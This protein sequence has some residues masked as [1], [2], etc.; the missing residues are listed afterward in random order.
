MAQLAP[1]DHVQVRHRRGRKL[2]GVLYPALVLAVRHG[3]ALLEYQGKSYTGLV[4]CDDRAEDD[5][6]VSETHRNAY[7]YTALPHKWL[8]AI[9]DAEQD[10]QG[11]SRAGET[12]S[13]YELLMERKRDSVAS[14]SPTTGWDRTEDTWTKSYLGH[15]LR[16]H[17]RLGFVFAQVGSLEV[18]RY[19]KR[20]K[21]NSA[22][23]CAVFRTHHV[24]ES[25]GPAKAPDWRHA[26]SGGK[27]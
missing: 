19:R 10:W 24:A 4:F 22:W 13:V 1:G 7:G 8:Q 26:L 15:R 23:R 18:G 6:V 27:Q 3:V 14:C 9:A 12:P 25:L 21:S 20:F 5:G 2:S 17:R 16:V 11:R